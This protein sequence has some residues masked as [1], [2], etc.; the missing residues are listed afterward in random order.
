MT[1]SVSRYEPRTMG[2]TRLPDL[3]DRLFNESFVLPSVM[4]RAFQ[5]IQG[6]RL[7][8][9]SDAYVIELALPG[10]DAEKTDISIVGRNVA[11]KAT[12]A[13]P[14]WENAAVIW[15]GLPVGDVVQQF[16][17]PGDVEAG[18]AEAHYEHGILTV[19]IPKAEHA[20]PRSIKVNVSK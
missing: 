6:S 5:Q 17:L 8:E 10:V 16:A 20:K 11:L 15:D 14:S 12:Y 9:T 1:T 2:L 18:N 19:R 13:T 3:M 4:D 7:I